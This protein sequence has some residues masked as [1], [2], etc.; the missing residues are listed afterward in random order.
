MVAAA[1]VERATGR[2]YADLLRELVIE[3]A[4]ME[5]TCTSAD[6][7]I[8]H[9]VAAVLGDHA[10]GTAVPSRT[11]RTTDARGLSSPGRIFHPLDE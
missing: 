1:A 6:E 11:A 7:A 8:F 4:G 3:P 5:L 2:H 9:R 10:P